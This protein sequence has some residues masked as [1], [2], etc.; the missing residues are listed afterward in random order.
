[1]NILNGQME[2]FYL[3]FQQ[4]N[5]CKIKNK[6]KESKMGCWSIAILYYIF[7]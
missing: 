7:F 5:R 4:Q 6:K 1:M 2:L 3:H